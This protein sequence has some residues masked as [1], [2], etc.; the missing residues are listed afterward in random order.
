MIQ[1]ALFAKATKF[2]R[3]KRTTSRY[4]DVR[5]EWHLTDGT[6]K[7]VETRSIAGVALARQFKAVIINAAGECLISRHRKLRPAQAAVVRA[8]DPKPKRKKVRR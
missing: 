1:Q 7:V 5:R 8:T 6:G 2:R 3:P 4:G